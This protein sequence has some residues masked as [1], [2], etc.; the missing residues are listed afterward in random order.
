[1]RAG[2]TLE[3]HENQ[4]VHVQTSL[5]TKL[6]RL[7]PRTKHI[8]NKLQCS[9]FVLT[10]SISFF[11][12]VSRMSMVCTLM[13]PVQIVLPSFLTTSS[14][15]AHKLTLFYPF[16]PS[17][18]LL[19]EDFIYLARQILLLPPFYLGVHPLPLVLVEGND[20]CTHTSCKWYANGNLFPKIK[21][22]LPMCTMEVGDGRRFD[23]VAHLSV[24]NPSFSRVLPSTLV[25]LLVHLVW[26]CNI[27]QVHHL[28]LGMDG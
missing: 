21:L 26:Q 5:F 13:K 17:F 9:C 16:K 8:A 15:C 10:P 20:E 6:S 1:M 7:Q 18:I 3:S 2:V 27:L 14:P 12:L 24:Y 4:G 11:A 25:Q 23:G 28:L 19:C 22:A